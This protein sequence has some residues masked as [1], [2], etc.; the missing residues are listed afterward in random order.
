MNPR[1]PVYIISKGRWERRQTSKTLEAMKVPYRIVVE[2]SEYEK[3]LE[4]IDEKKILKLPEDF[5]KRGEGGIPVR[6]WVWEHRDRRSR[7]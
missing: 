7:K 1:F 3:Y 5:S 4:F 6:N 2:P